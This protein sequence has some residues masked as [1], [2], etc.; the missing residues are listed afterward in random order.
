MSAAMAYPIEPNS[1]RAV[2][3]VRDASS[4]CGQAVSCKHGGP[5]QDRLASPTLVPVDPPGLVESDPPKADRVARP[6][7]SESIEVGRDDMRDV[8]VSPH[9]PASR[10]QDDQAAAGRLDR[11]RGHRSR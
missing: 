8:R 9:R 10:A 4:P 5:H 2:V 11:A 1:T 3:M 6:G 7:L